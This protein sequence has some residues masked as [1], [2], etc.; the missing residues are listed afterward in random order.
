MTSCICTYRWLSCRG[1]RGSSYDDD[2][3]AGDGDVRDGDVR[4]DDNGP[5]GAV[6]NG[7]SGHDGNIRDGDNGHVE[8]TRKLRWQ[9]HEDGLG[10]DLTCTAHFA[11]LRNDVLAGST[12]ECLVVIEVVTL[13]QCPLQLGA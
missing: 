10:M 4:E 5:D 1:D 2:D 9:E 7:K 11:Y 6:R 8:D 12:R 13:R 3:D